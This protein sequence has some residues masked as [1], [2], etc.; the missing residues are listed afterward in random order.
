MTSD[1][2]N[3]DDPEV[4]ETES[5]IIDDEIELPVEDELEPPLEED[6]PTVRHDETGEL[7]PVEDE[8][9]SPE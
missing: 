4:D 9:D 7:V 2:F 3:P 1:P 5:T 6:D 8:E